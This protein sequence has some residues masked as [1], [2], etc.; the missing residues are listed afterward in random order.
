MLRDIDAFA[1]SGA[2]ASAVCISCQQGTY[3]S[4]SGNLISESSV[5]KGWSQPPARFARVAGS[6]SSD[7]CQLCSSGTYSSRSGAQDSVFCIS[8][9]AATRTCNKYVK[10]TL[11][12]LPFH[13]CVKVCRI[14]PHAMPALEGHIQVSQV[15]RGNKGLR[16]SKF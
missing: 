8:R 13:L 11:N 2:S 12:S 15:Y 10:Y 3:S 7:S 1:E 14:R 4:I 6:S 9:F 16:F 5:I